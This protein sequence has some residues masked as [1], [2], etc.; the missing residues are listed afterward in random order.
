MYRIKYV[1]SIMKT[2]R[3][4]LQELKLKL[5]RNRQQP[6]VLFQENIFQ[7]VDTNKS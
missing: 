5:Q 7:K 2:N 4:C 6:L 1:R 3:Y